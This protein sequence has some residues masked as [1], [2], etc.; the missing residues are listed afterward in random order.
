KASVQP[1]R[2]SER[3]ALYP[4]ARSLPRNRLALAIGAAY[5]SHADLVARWPRIRLRFEPERPSRSLPESGRWRRRAINS[6]LDR[7]DIPGCV[8]QRRFAAVYEHEW[9]VVLPAAPGAWLEA[10]GLAQDGILKG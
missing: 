4:A 8:S 7:G 6:P 1:S 3:L 9:Q 5:G 2:P 10:R